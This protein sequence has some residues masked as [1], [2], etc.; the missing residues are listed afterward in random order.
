MP[1][2]SLRGFPVNQTN[3]AGRRRFSLTERF[4]LDLRAEYFNALNH[5]MFS[6]YPDFQLLVYVQT[7]G[8]GQINQTLNNALGGLNPLYQVGGPRSANSR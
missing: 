6:P 4:S 1:G 5:P 2:N 3:L 7:P 8:F